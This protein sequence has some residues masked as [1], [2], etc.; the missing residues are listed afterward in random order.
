MTCHAPLVS[1]PRVS[2]ARLPTPLELVPRLLPAVLGA[3]A[4]LPQLYLKRDDLTGAELTG[5]KVRKLELLLA[6]ALAR[7]ADTILTCGGEQ[8]NHCRATALAAAKLGL[9]CILLLR[10]AEPS[11]PPPPTGNLLLSALSGAELRFVS[12]A[13]YADRAARMTAICDELGRQGRS[14]YIIPEGGSN[15]LG[16]LGYVACIEELRAQLPNPER[17]TTVVYAAGSGGTG[18][19]LLLGVAL[20]KLPWRVVGINVCDDRAYFVQRIGDILAETANAFAIE[21]A[22]TLA[23]TREHSIDIRDGYVGRGYALS[24]PTEL[25]MI[26]DI[27]HATGCVLDPVYTGKA[28]YGLCEEL[29]A[30]P[31]SLG[32]RIVFVHTGGIYGLLAKAEELA[33][34]VRSR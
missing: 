27:C 34:I 5:N 2:L 33:P 1:L 7:G 15:A 13:E 30:D 16:S 18:A 6:D 29:R 24:Q 11:L 17:P 19:G 22:G 14:G 8:S 9:R 28:M 21:E 31:A 12:R 25:A 4:D 3:Q 10:V 23:K 26:R 20:L 32:E